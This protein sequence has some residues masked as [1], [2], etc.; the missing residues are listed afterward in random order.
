MLTFRQL[1]LAGFVNAKLLAADKTKNVNN[2]IDIAKYLK[3]KAK[4]LIN[5]M[6]NFRSRK[7]KLRLEIVR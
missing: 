4:I 6:S 7:Q 2:D 1:I 5:S 3:F